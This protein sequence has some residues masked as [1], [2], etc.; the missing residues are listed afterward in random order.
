VF[1]QLACWHQLQDG[2]PKD[3]LPAI[4]EST[5]SDGR[6]NVGKDMEQFTLSRIFQ[7]LNGVAPAA[8]AQ[9]R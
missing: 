1:R 5:R 6:K 4:G 2:P 7:I 3:M 8:K 9:K